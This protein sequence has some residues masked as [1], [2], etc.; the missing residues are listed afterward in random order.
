VCQPSP[1]APTPAL[2]NP[3]N[4]DCYKFKNRE[5]HEPGARTQ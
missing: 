3:Q 1:D 2:Q 4:L 5:S